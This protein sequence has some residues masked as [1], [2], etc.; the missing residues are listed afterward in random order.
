MP[1]VTA[2]AVAANSH[3]GDAAARR[4]QQAMER[5]ILECNA[6]GISNEEVNSPII[7]RRMRL[8]HQRELLLITKEEHEKQMLECAL[9]YAQRLHE[10]TRAHQEHVANMEAVF[11]A[12]VQSI[13]ESIDG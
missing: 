11:R 4:L 8:A 7:A 1:I 12:E 13:E 10:L 6:E 5:A 2:H 9:T 3:F